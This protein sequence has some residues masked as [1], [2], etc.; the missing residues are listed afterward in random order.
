M[1]QRVRRPTNWSRF[2]CLR[3][4]KVNLRRPLLPTPRGIDVTLSPTTIAVDYLSDYCCF[5]VGR[6]QIVMWRRV[7]PDH[8]VEGHV[9]VV[10]NAAPYH[11]RSSSAPSRTLAPG[12]RTPSIDYY[13]FVIK[14]CSINQHMVAG[15]WRLGFVLLRL[16]ATMAGHTWIDCARWWFCG[17]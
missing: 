13:N 14:C 2:H 15:G 5:V 4:A 17:Q 3:V 16:S 6:T 11:V 9:A 12:H 10:R 8:D 7:T 1:R